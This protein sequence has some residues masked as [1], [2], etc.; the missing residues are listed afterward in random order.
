MR[1]KRRKAVWAIFAVSFFLSLSGVL[2]SKADF[3]TGIII[4]SCVVTGLI[5]FGIRLG[6]VDVYRKKRNRENKPLIQPAIKRQC[7][8]VFS[9]VQEY[10]IYAAILALP[11]S[12][13][14]LEVAISIAIGSWIIRKVLLQE[15]RIVRT[16]LN[17]PIF[18]FFAASALSVINTSNV[19]ESLEA[20]FFKLGE[21]ILLFFVVVETL[22]SKVK[23][24]KLFIA[25]SIIAVLVGMS[26]V[27][28]PLTRYDFLRWRPCLIGGKVA[29]PFSMPNELAGWVITLLPVWL[30]MLFYKVD[31]RAFKLCIGTI[32]ILLLTALLMTKVRG[33]YLAFAGA[34]IFTT[35]IKRKGLRTG[36]MTMATLLIVMLIVNAILM[37]YF[38]GLTEASVYDRLWWW[39]TAWQMIQEHPLIGVGVNNFHS[40]YTHYN[41]NVNSNP[42][43]AHNCYLQMTAE[44][45]ILGFGAFVWILVALFAYLFKKWLPIQDG[46][47]GHMILG[48]TGGI[49]AML[50]H[51]VVDTNLYS[52]QL[53]ALLWFMIGAV[54]GVAQISEKGGELS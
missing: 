43:Y 42:A 31:R 22:D 18:F 32:I 37:F 20:L 52:L 19:G 26:A 36:L 15:Y 4:L 23:L 24:K 21:Y 17:A 9:I 38:H 46:F 7:A 29:G 40:V 6:T 11:V 14:M 51:S 53:A 49:V 5:L 45:G 12:K 33:A 1:L 41:V 39:K 50:L 3:R 54:V 10:S 28:Q 44:V 2:M 48:L 35:W 30:A 34:L 16:P 13:A 25:L 27:L 8:T 47:Y